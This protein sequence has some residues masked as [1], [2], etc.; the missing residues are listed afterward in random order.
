MPADASE[1]TVETLDRAFNIAI[2]GGNSHVN[3]T[4]ATASGSGSHTVSAESSIKNAQHV[5]ALWPALRAELA[6]LGLP[7]EELE[8]LHGVLLSDADYGNGLGPATSSWLG[9]LS[10][11]LATGALA[12]GSAASSEA[13]SH[14]VLKALGLA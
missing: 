2:Y 8:E 9:R 7:G 1:P 11:K 4:T 14:A 12:V 5:E 6:E 3:V 10:G 13:I